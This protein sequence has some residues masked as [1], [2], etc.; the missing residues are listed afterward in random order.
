MYKL[1]S[2]GNDN[3][4]FHLPGNTPAEVHKNDDVCALVEQFPGVATQ[5]PLS[6]YGV[7]SVQFIEKMGVSILETH[8]YAKAMKLSFNIFKFKRRFC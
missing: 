2:C 5:C 8:A 7:V 3:D 6:Q 1:K 4:H